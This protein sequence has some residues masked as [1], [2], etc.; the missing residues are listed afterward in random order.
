MSHMLIFDYRCRCFMKDDL[1]KAAASLQ[2]LNGELSSSVP[3]KR[4]PELLL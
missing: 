4:D 2:F 3:L 1:S